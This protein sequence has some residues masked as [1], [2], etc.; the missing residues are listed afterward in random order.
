M[1]SN[2]AMRVA[3]TNFYFTEPSSPVQPQ[4]DFCAGLKNVAGMV[5]KFLTPSDIHNLKLTSHS[6]YQVAREALFWERNRV[7][8]EFL[9]VKQALMELNWTG[10]LTEE[11]DRLVGTSCFTNPDTAFAEEIE[12]GL[13]LSLCFHMNQLTQKDIT[14]LINKLLGAGKQSIVSKL[15]S[16]E[17]IELAKLTA[18]AESM[19]DTAKKLRVFQGIE[20]AR[21]SSEVTHLCLQ[22]FIEAELFDPDKLLVVVNNLLKSGEKE[23]VDFA[24]ECMKQITSEGGQERMIEQVAEF[25]NRAYLLRIDRKVL[26]EDRISQLDGAVSSLCEEQMNAVD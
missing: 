14:L 13:Y 24:F 25:R 26:S 19:F 4:R 10:P 8:K 17:K 3:M 20:A 11:I 21:N 6:G 18:H 23:R 2:I 22:G 12:G 1:D 16:Q 7:K 15:F 5:G 9:A